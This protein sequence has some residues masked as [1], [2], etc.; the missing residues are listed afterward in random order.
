MSSWPF[1]RGL[2]PL[3]DHRF[4]HRNIDPFADD[5]AQGI[6]VVDWASNASQPSPCTRAM[7]LPENPS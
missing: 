3:Q 4:L 7:Q 5:I 6:I 2:F 1:R